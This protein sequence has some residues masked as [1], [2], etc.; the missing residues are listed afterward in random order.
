MHL[1]QKVMQK[2]A[3]DSKRSSECQV[4]YP[5]LAVTPLFLP[6]RHQALLLAQL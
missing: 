3:H 4:K 5:A 1:Q 2:S 6:V